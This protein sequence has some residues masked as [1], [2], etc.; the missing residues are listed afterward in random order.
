MTPVSFLLFV[1]NLTV[2][3]VYN[4]YSVSEEAAD[5]IRQY[6]FH[7]TKLLEMHP[8][9]NINDIQVA[10]ATRCHYDCKGLSS[11]SILLKCNFSGNS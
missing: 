7:T 6:C 9:G 11:F 5:D 3:S 10:I 4:N 8:H 1:P 2:F